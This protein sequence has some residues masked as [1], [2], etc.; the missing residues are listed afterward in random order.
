MLQVELMSNAE[1]CMVS[2]GHRGRLMI[3]RE[4]LWYSLIDPKGLMGFFECEVRS[5][6]PRLSRGRGRDWLEDG[7]E[8]SGRCATQLLFRVTARRPAGY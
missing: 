6:E 7:G 3:H 5:V 2:Q 8:D 1:K 4:S